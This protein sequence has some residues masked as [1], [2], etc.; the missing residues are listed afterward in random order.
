M[1]RFDRYDPGQFSWV[2][3]MS[4]D[5]D[6]ASGFY[7]TLFGWTLERTQDDTGGAYTMFR[8]DG[9]EVAGLGALPAELAA[10]GVPPHWNSYVTVDDADVTA[11]RVQELGGQLHMPVIDIQVQGQRVG[12]MTTLADP[13]GASLSIWEPGSHRGSGLAN[14]P[15]TLCWNEL[16]ARDVEGSVA[17]YE[18]LFG[19]KVRP[20]DAENGYREIAVGDRANGGIL[21]WRAEMGDFPPS[22]TPYFAVADCDASVAKVR[23]LGGNALMGPVDIEPGRF[24]VVSDPQGAVFNVMFLKNPDA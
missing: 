7:G 21:P 13:S 3:L 10:A 4:P 16:C 24:A 19:W 20:G 8:L 9:V 23:E 18:A 15:G 12:R 1:A 14:V 2:D 6:A 22:W 5:V 17:F 11:A